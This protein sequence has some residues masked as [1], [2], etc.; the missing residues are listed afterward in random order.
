VKFGEGCVLLDLMDTAIREELTA[1]RDQYFRLYPN[2]STFMIVSNFDQPETLEAIEALIGKIQ[3]VRDSDIFSIV[4]VRGKSDL[5][6]PM[7]QKARV[8]RW[9]EKNKVPFLCTSA[10]EDINVELSFRVCARVHMQRCPG[11]K[12]VV[13]RIS[14]QNNTRK[15]KGKISLV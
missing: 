7:R 14:N 9:S 3:R 10:K 4:L 11:A 5:K 12:P 15:A 2:H 8:L 1:L 6:K 13:R